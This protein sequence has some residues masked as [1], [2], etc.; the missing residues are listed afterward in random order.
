MGHNSVKIAYCH[1]NMFKKLIVFLGENHTLKFQTYLVALKTL[2]TLYM[3]DINME[4]N[5]SH[6]T[7]GNSTET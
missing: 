5:L 3:V 1:K 4:K 2:F 6:N 7:K